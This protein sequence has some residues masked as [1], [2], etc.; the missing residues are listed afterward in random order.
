MNG[1]N[2][3]DTNIGE[4]SLFQLKNG[5]LHLVYILNSFFSM[6]KLNGINTE[7]IA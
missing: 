2:A 3:E 5:I 6:Y 4:E 1:Q 7:Q